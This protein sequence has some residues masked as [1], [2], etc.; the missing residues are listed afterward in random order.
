MTRHEEKDKQYFENGEAYIQY[1]EEEANV[2]MSE[3]EAKFRPLDTKERIQLMDYP[4]ELC[5]ALSVTPK[6]TVQNICA[7]AHTPR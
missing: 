5:D 4:C 2:I 6:S 1:T 7:L 3:Q